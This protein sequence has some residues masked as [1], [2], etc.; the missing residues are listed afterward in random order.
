MAERTIL[1]DD[2]DGS[3]AV[4]TV[5]FGLDGKAYTIDLNADHAKA[6]RENLD[7]YIEAA[8]RVGGQGGGKPTSKPRPSR[9]QT[10]AIRAWARQNG[11]EISERGRISAPILKAYQA[12]H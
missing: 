12:A 2:L 4:E 3:D 6:L 7:E 8:R 9:E 5:S 10:A 11:H 1:V